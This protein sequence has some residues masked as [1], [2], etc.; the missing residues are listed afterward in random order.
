MKKLLLACGVAVLA[1]SMGSCDSKKSGEQNELTSL[2]DSISTLAGEAS[3]MDWLGRY[4]QLPEEERAKFSKKE[5]ERGVEAILLADTTDQGFLVGLQIGQQLMQQVYQM[6]SAGIPVDHKAVANEFKKAFNGDS[7]DGTQVMALQS[8]L[9]QLRRRAFE[10]ADKK[11]EEEA[12]K[13]PEA[14][15]NV[16]AG[17]K[18][19]TN[20]KAEDPSIVTTPSGL[21]YKV[22]KEGEGEPVGDARALVNYKGS[23]VD[24][25]TFDAGEGAKFSAANVIPGFGEGLKMMKKGGV[26]TLIIPADIAYGAKAVGNIP[27]MSTLIFEVEVLDIEK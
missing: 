10:L 21:S 4:N 7:V 13:T 16:E 6:E 25:T 27:P 26:Y 24:G 5:I 15:A 22:V 19:I 20:A 14:I 17:Q 9:G 2:G 23:L 8:Q 11:R 1:L 3:G 18:Y 12:A